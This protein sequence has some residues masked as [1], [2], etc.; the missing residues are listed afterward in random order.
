MQ[1]CTRSMLHRVIL[2]CHGVSQQLIPECASFILTADFSSSSAFHAD[3][4]PPSSSRQRADLRHK[5][6]KHRQDFLLSKERIKLNLRT[7]RD[8][9][10]RKMKEIVVVGAA[11]FLDFY[12]LPN[13][14][15]LPRLLRAYLYCSIHL[16]RAT[17]VSTLNFLTFVA[18]RKYFHH[19]EPSVRSTDSSNSIY[20]P[21]NPS[22][23]FPAGLWSCILCRPHWSGTNRKDYSN[24]PTRIFSM[25]TVWWDDTAPHGVLQC[26]RRWIILII[27]VVRWLYR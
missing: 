23:E 7:Q 2:G 13:G 10:V 1:V 12:F 4:L 3:R 14:L 20:W 21:F 16:S 8:E 19:S 25:S 18:E 17:V 22:R 9:T 5:Y 24:F 26:L 15:F 27:A 11:W 6:Q